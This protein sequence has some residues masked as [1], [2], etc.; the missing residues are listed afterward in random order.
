MDLVEALLL[1]VVAEEAK[2]IA[3]RTD[4]HTTD[5]PGPD[6][7]YH[8]RYELTIEHDDVRLDSMKQHDRFEF[9]ERMSVRWA[10]R[11]ARLKSEG[12]GS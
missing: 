3:L 2:V 9:A 1:R 7:R 6:C 4:V 11:A 8:T 12:D 10:E 5:E